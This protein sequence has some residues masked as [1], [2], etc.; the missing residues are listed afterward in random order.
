MS[1]ASDVAAA[2]TYESVYQNRPTLIRIGPLLFT[3]AFPLLPDNVL[4]WVAQ[5]TC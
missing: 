3:A 4:A 1:A 5:L 2:G